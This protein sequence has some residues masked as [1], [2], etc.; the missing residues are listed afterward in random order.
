MRRGGTG[1]VAHLP[2]YDWPEIRAETDALWNA[3][4]EAIR[5]RGIEAPEALDRSGQTRRLWAAPELVLG[6]TCGL[7]FV[8]TLRGRVGLVGTPTYALEGVGP[9]EYC[10]VIVVAEGQTAEGPGDLAGARP[11]VNSRDS[12]SGYAALMH[13][14][15]PAAQAGRL[16]GPPVLTGSHRASV[17]ALAQGRAEVAAIDAVSWELARR[18]EP[19]AAALRVLARTD[20]A[21]GL[22]LITGR[23]GREATLAAAVEEAIAA[24]PDASRAALLVTGLARRRG[25]DYDVIRDRLAAAEARHVLPGTGD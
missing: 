2:M 8:R 12:Q 3:M 11:A 22:P 13:W 14:G 1:G 16:Y 15:A 25:P 18:H 19:A 4:R 7:P 24:L 17:Q 6:Q 21:P 9:G 23:R 5:D 10:S 20:P